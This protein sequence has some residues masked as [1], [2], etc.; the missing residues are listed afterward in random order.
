MTSKPL[1]VNAN[2]TR[3]RV[4]WEMLAVEVVRQSAR[5]KMR[6]VAFG[7]EVGGMGIELVGTWEPRWQEGTCSVGLMP[8]IG[9]MEAAIKVPSMGSKENLGQKTL[10]V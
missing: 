8:H 4:F 10:S 7:V 6:R 1:I 9:E 3:G 5:V 2:L